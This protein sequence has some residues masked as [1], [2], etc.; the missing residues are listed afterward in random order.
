MELLSNLSRNKY[1]PSLKLFKEYF[2]KINYQNITSGLHL[3]K[4]KACFIDVEKI[5]I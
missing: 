2:N 4:L 3:L 5:R 1:P